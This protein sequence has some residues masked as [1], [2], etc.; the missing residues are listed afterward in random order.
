[1][2]DDTT[3]ILELTPREAAVILELTG[4]ISWAQGAYRKEAES[5]CRAL[6]QIPESLLPK[7]WTYSALGPVEP[8]LIW[9]DEELDL[10]LSYGN[11]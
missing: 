11:V 8:G 10:T 4:V 5:I 3:I 9:L 6:E 7:P 1:M 2:T